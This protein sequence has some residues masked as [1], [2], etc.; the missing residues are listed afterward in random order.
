VVR[1]Q[2]HYLSR[3]HEDQPSAHFAQDLYEFRGS[4]ARING[5]PVLIAGELSPLA[6]EE[7][8]KP[9][10]CSTGCAG[11]LQYWAS[12]RPRGYVQIDSP[13]SRWICRVSRNAPMNRLRCHRQA[14]RTQESGDY[15]VG[16]TT[17]G[18]PQVFRSTC[19][20]WTLVRAQR[21]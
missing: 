18:W 10:H 14:C 16:L 6:G 20:T 8:F 11:Y 3:V 12:F 7:R 1:H 15:F 4:S 17:P 2:Y 13:T 5:K 9:P 21:N 19:C